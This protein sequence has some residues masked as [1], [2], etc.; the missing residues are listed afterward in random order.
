MIEYISGAATF[1]VLLSINKAIIEP[2]AKAAGRKLLDKH[3]GTVCAL[4]DDSLEKFGLDFNPE[5]AI[6]DHLNLEDE[7]LSEE[8]KDR[9]VEEVFKQWDLRKA[10]HCPAR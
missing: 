9:I 3:L 8:D 7:K 5:E 2:L 6:R 10:A 1:F 4:L